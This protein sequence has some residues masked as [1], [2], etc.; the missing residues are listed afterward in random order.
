MDA[1]AILQSSLPQIY[2]LVRLTEALRGNYT[3]ED[4]DAGY[5]EWHE[6]VKH[7]NER[8][9]EQSKR[10][11]RIIRQQLRLFG[12]E[13]NSELM[14]DEELEARHD[15]LIVKPK[16]VD[17]AECDD[18]REVEMK[19]KYFDMQ[20]SHANDV[21]CIDDRRMMGA[22]KARETRS[23]SDDETGSGIGVDVCFLPQP[24]VDTESD[25]EFEPKRRSKRRKKECRESNAAYRKICSSPLVGAS[26]SHVS[27]S[28]EKSSF[29]KTEID[30]A[31]K[32]GCVKTKNALDMSDL[33]ADDKPPTRKSPPETLYSD[34]CLS[35]APLAAAKHSARSKISATPANTKKSYTASSRAPKSRPPRKC[36]DCKESTTQY[37]QCNYWK[38][39]GNKCGKSFC[40]NCLSSKY[41]LGED[42]LSPFNPDG[43]P[44]EEI[45]MCSS[46]DVEWHCP[47]CLGT[48][49]CIAC[50]R[51]RKKDVERGG[52]QWEKLRKS[53]RRSAG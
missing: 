26:N 27:L 22:T 53:S 30:K 51:Q 41:T 25:E 35:S 29:K 31:D 7:Q 49:E 42:A 52:S 9:E 32:E 20:Q 33:L 17:I 21:E 2:Q 5:D 15:S 4:G 38:L 24:E 45:V 14:M 36:H 43:I 10:E 47:S 28:V 6:W 8:E 39:S 44:I 40:I 18:V 1:M 13:N 16:E 12:K 23:R 50:V 37:R 19:E 3:I 34:I 46:L 11:Q 48:C